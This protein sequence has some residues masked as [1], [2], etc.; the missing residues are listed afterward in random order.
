MLGPGG[1]GGAGAWDAA[2]VGAPFAVSMAKGLWR[3]YYHGY[4]KG[5]PT[6]LLPASASHS[7]TLRLSVADTC[8]DA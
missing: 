7:E 4:S 1:S 6:R 8:V 2:G 3:L 5:A